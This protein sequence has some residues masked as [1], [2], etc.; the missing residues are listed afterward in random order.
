MDIISFLPSTGASAF[1]GV[2]VT[3]QLLPPRQIDA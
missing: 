1:G 3:P 2:V